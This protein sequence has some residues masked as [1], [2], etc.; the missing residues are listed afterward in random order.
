LAAAMMT[1]ESIPARPMRYV[2]FAGKKGFAP[3]WLS[4]MWVHESKLPLRIGWTEGPQKM[5][6]SPGQQ[7]IAAFNTESDPLELD[8]KVLRAGDPSYKTQTAA[9][10][11]WFESTDLEESDVKLSSRDVEVLKSLGYIQ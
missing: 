6:W 2:A 8:A 9:L 5:I 7:S 11:R 10:R 3:N 1:G 4:W